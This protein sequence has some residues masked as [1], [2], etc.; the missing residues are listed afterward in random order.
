VGQFAGI[1]GGGGTFGSSPSSPSS[2]ALMELTVIA[3]DGISFSSASSVSAS[4]IHHG[5]KRAE[6]LLSCHGAI[7]LL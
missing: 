2:S 5:T 7:L 4:K 6:R 1:P 3:A